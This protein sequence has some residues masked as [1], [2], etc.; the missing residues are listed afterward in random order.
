MAFILS[1]PPGFTDLPDSL[2]QAGAPA[3][4]FVASALKDN[5]A[6]GSVVPEVFYNTLHNGDVVPLPVSSVDGYQYLR[7]ELIYVWEIQNTVNNENGTPS[8]PNQ[9]LWCEWFVEPDTG[10]VHSTETYG[11]DPVN[12]W[13][14]TNDGIL[15]VWAFGIRGRKL[16]SLAVSPAFADMPA[17]NFASDNAASQTN[18]QKLS[19]NAKLASV[20]CEVFPMNPSNA[21]VWQPN[22]FY[23]AGALVQP[24]G[25]QANGFWFIAA[26]AGTSGALEPAWP[27]IL[28]SSVPVNDGSIVWN[29]AGAGFYH[30]QQVPFPVSS[31]DG[32][33][34]SSQD[35]IVPFLAF[36]STQAIPFAKNLKTQI[37]SGGRI[38]KLAKSISPVQPPNPVQGSPGIGVPGVPPLGGSPQTI[39]PGTLQ[40]WTPQI[41]TPAAPVLSSVAGGG[42][43][44]MTYY[45]KITYTSPNGETTASAESSLAVA[46][47]NLLSV[48]SPAASGAAS[49]WKVYV[50][51]APGAETLQSLSPLAIA[52]AWTESTQGIQTTSAAP[53]SVNTTGFIPSP[54]EANI[55]PFL[56]PGTAATEFGVVSLNIQYRNGDSTDGTAMVWLLCF[57]KVAA[58]TPPGGALFVDMSTDSFTTGNPLRSDL[59]QNVNE[60]A[61]FS[62]LRPEIFSYAIDPGISTT[63]PIPKSTIDGYQ[64]GRGELTY[65]WF[66]TDSGPSPWRINDFMM[67]V[68]PQSG[69]LN[70]RN[71]YYHDGGLATVIYG[72]GGLLQHSNMDSWS[73]KPS[74]TVVVFARR[75]HETLLQSPLVISG[76]GQTPAPP[77]PFNLIPNG[78]F[79][80]WSVPDKSAALYNGVADDW[81]IVQ[82]VNTAVFKQLPGF[83]GS[84][85][86][87]G[88]GMKP[89]GSTL[90]HRQQMPPPGGNSLASIASFIIPV[91]PGGT[92]K[93]HFLA[94]VQN[95][96]LNPDQINYGFYAR[97]HLLAAAVDGTP[98]LST[99]TTFELLGTD[100]TLPPGTAAGNNPGGSVLTSPPNVTPFDFTFTVPLSGATA[101]STSAGKSVLS[102]AIGFTPA[103]VYIEFL[104][105]DIIVP[106]GIEFG[107]LWR[108][109]ELDNAI[110]QDLTSGSTNLN[111]QGGIPTP[112][113]GDNSAFTFSTTSS[114]ISFWWTAFSLAYSNGSMVNIPASGSSGSPAKTFSGLAASTTYHVSARYNIVTFSVELRADAATLPPATIN[115][116]LNADGFIPI[117]FDWQIATPSGGSTGGGG[118]S[119]GG[120]SCFTGET[121][122]KTAQG[123][124]A[125]ENLPDV[126]EIENETGKHLADVLVHEDCDDWVI[127]LGT[128]RV[129]IT[130]GLRWASRWITAGDLFKGTPPS[131]HRGKM[132]NLH[133]RGGREED[134][135]FII[136]GGWVAH[137]KTRSVL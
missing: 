8:A 114:S 2:L 74:V 20:Q 111:N 100:L 104:L 49:G 15:S 21:P 105:W 67:F 64:Y 133:V 51:M 124:L 32:Y 48:A 34:Y 26:K 136:E 52:S 135:H 62:I 78:D 90:G 5:A 110:L 96:F 95:Q 24:S 45:V 27:G 69:I 17:S 77:G 101:A 54:A 22:T 134:K 102:A 42:L 16:R 137:N 4:G 35:T 81:G 97:V 50:G 109:L 119:T 93:F 82:Q 89:S 18:L 37:T 60:N 98:D 127:P 113:G 132:Y 28:F 1:E 126:V 6:F 13:T 53:P 107:F 131:R 117:F 71:D 129:N 103:Y 85:Y 83:G 76:G 44:A 63:V 31:F 123:F 120:S 99:D 23:N 68:D 121:K 65:L 118:G 7:E 66:F 94:S 61:K 84:L 122:V 47:N 125:F 3:T 43:P 57:R 58:M 91:W 70:T 106:F 11:T 128:G 87:Q 116:W 25:A 56:S 55:Q 19:H 39:W 29:I 112:A 9:L 10:K 30:G 14:Q 80:I 108:F 73:G 46:A 79:S 92:Y 86:S 33:Q 36:M 88:I 130:H 115:N 38:T 12:S 72:P 59:M 41:A 75:Q 40:N